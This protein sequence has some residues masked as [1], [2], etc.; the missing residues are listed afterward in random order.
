MTDEVEPLFEV[1]QLAHVEILSPDPARTLWFFTD[2]LGMEVTETRGQSAYLRAYEDR[3]HH[4]LK[5]TEA[6][7]PGMGHCAWRTTSARALERRVRVL[8]ESGQ[9]RG[10]IEDETGH[11]PAYAFDSPDGHRMEVLWEVERARARPGTETHLKNRVSRRP[12]HG[13]PV[14]R[15]DHV[16]VLA[17]DVTATKDFLID[18]LGFRLRERKVL[19]GDVEAG[20]WLSV[21]AL[22]HDIAVMQD[23]LGP[24][25][26]FHH[27]CYWYG[28][29]QHLWDVADVFVDQGIHIE[30][31]PGKHGTTQALFLYVYE[32]GGNRIELFGD[33][34]YLILDPD[35]EPITWSGEEELLRGTSWLGA[36]APTEFYLYGTPPVTEAESEPAPSAR[37]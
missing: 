15:L 6:P 8:E 19:P 31:G 32:P 35:W 30:H 4:T 2:L 29:P 26:R 33:A 37:T 21:N 14:R 20:A 1:A 24:G 7:Q 18:R 16:N 5:V 27:V 17:R 9:G 22:V 11:G 28:Y 23:R 25:G 3:D 34:G 12:L 13:V 36:I 10:W